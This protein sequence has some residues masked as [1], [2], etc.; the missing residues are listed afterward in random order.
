MGVAI[1]LS[2]KWVQRL[3]NYE[4]LTK[5]YSSRIFRVGRGGGNFGRKLTISCL[6]GKFILFICL[7]IIIV[8]SSSWAQTERADE[9][10][11]MS[12]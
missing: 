1:F 11:L 5:K 3:P 7:V 4:I 8:Q 12:S 10:F 2:I 9:T 6:L